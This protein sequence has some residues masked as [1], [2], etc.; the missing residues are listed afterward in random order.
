MSTTDKRQC[1]AAAAAA[2]AET[3][4]MKTERPLVATRYM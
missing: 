2:A 3:V 4:H 1:P